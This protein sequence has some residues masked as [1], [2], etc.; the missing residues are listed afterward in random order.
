MDRTIDSLGPNSLRFFLLFLLL[1]TVIVSASPTLAAGDASNDVPT[2]PS[3]QRKPLSKRAKGQ[4]PDFPS[5]YNGRVQ[6]G[7][8]LKSLFPLGDAAA[9]RRNNKHPVASPWQD[10]AQVQRWGWT[11]EINWAPF[12]SA[13]TDSESESDSEWDF[14]AEPGFGNTLNNAFADPRYRVDPSENGLSTYKHSKPFYLRDGKIGKP[15]EASYQN[16]VNPR[17]GALIF[18]RNFSPR[19]E[20]ARSH[21]GT[22]PELEQLS[23]LAYF[24]WHEACQIK[25]VHPSS[26]RL[27]YRTHITYVNTFNI[28][29]Q[30]LYRQGHKSVPGWN[31]RAVLSMESDEGLAILGSTHG[32][33]AALFLIQHKAALGNKRITEVTVWGTYGGFQFDANPLYASLNLRFTVSD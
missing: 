8:Y 24:Q 13:D 25:R 15:T 17:S 9:T 33:G 12:G 27:I 2:V 5:D 7:R 20:V 28:V 21:T 11:R 31:N 6:K 26:I 19:Y 23:D 18:D 14:D 30:A 29:S 16:V 3:L 4:F 10:P 32:A 22:V 1:Q